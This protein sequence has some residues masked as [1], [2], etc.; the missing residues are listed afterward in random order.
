MTSNGTHGKIPRP[1]KPFLG[2]DGR[3]KIATLLK[4]GSSRRTNLSI[5]AE[6]EAKLFVR[7]SSIE[8]SLG[9]WFAIKRYLA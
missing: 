1:N 7:K 5:A 6:L 2:G 3:G 4:L 9:T 8:I